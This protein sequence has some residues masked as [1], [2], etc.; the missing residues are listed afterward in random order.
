MAP[1]PTTVTAAPS[2]WPGTTSSVPVSSIVIYGPAGCGKSRHADTLAAFF[3]KKLIVSDWRLDDD[4]PDDALCLSND[5]RL[6]DLCVLP[7]SSQSGVVVV[8]AYS[9]AADRLHLS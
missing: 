4:V 8:I 9:E 5:D 6:R 2:P 3:G 7:Q 1:S